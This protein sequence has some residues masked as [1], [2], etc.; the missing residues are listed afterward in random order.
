MKVKA[1]KRG[2][3]LVELVVVIAILA[4]YCGNSNSL[5]YKYFRFYNSFFW[6]S[7]ST[8]SKPRVPKCL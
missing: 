1:N 2:F 8:N 7:A 3:T 4:Y 5:S 6:R